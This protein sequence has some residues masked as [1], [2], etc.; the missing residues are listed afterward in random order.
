MCSGPMS[1]GVRDSFIVKSLTTRPR[2][3]S[4]YNLREPT[5]SEPGGYPDDQTEESM[6]D[7][8][9]QIYRTALNNATRK[10]STTTPI[11]TTK[12]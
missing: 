4:D 1:T 3:L 10:R 11:P 2:K 9:E 7:K 12:K 8:R 5:N 6:T